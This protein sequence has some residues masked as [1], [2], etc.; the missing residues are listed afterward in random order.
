MHDRLISVII[1]TY[2]RGK[3][4]RRAIESV[5][6]QSYHQL[7][8]IVVDDGST[9]GTDQQ[10]NEIQD[11]RFK[12]IKLT[13]NL[14]ACHARN[15]GIEE[16]TGFYIAFQ[17]SDDFWHPDKLEKQVNV[18]NQTGADV[19]GCG[20]IECI[21]EGQA[22][23]S[24]IPI[25]A[26]SGF[27]T[28]KQVAGKTLFVTSTFLARA[29]VLKQ[30]LFDE[31]LPRYQDYELIIRLIQRYR[32]YFM[33]EA[34]V[35]KFEQKDSITWSN[36]RFARAVQAEEIILAKHGSIIEESGEMPFHL[37]RLINAKTMERL[38]CDKECEMLFNSDKSLKSMIIYILHKIRLLRC[39]YSLLSKYHAK[40]YRIIRRGKR[41]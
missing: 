26:K 15:V 17:D 39:C 6:A 32:I 30:N 7:E 28:T 34:L 5:L 4:I 41:N 40:R 18:M 20:V 16:A 2:N 22:Y 10:I 23:V 14:G 25:D 24:P 12:Y 35:N 3:T 13:S 8:L 1:P 38:P 36:T 33:N 9:D 21:E 19:V 31:N 37:R 27:C 11:K 29:D